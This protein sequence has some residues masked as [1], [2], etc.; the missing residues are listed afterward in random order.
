MMDESQ[1]AKKRAYDKKWRSDHPGY[2]AERARKYREKFME[3]H[4]CTCLNCGAKFKGYKASYCTP[5][6]M[7]AARKRAFSKPTQVKPI[8]VKRNKFERLALYVQKNNL[9]KILQY[10]PRSNESDF[11][12]LQSYIRRNNLL[13]YIKSIPRFE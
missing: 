8:V 10:I 7:I 12:A 3:T 9:K 6:C 2:D 5:E 1:K 4:V 11:L 13:G